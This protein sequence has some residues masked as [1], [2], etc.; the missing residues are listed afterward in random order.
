[1]DAIVLVSEIEYEST[2]IDCTFKDLEGEKVS[3]I[4]LDQQTLTISSANES[5]I[6]FSGNVAS[7]GTTIL[8]I[9][10]KLNLGKV[11][12]SMNKGT[13]GACL[14]LVSSTLKAT[15][16]Q[17]LANRAQEGGVIFAI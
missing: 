12:M 15:S 4:F 14:K 6:N 13:Q 16:S 7:D 8:A 11:V 3:A 17:F 5:L 10:S 9:N 2:L 1:L